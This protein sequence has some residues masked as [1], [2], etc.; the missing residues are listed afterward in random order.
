[1]TNNTAH[2]LPERSPQPHPLWSRR[3]RHYDDD[4]GCE[5]PSS[6]RQPRRRS[7]GPPQ[8]IVIDDE[9]SMVSRITTPTFVTATTTSTT[10][11]SPPPPN[12]QNNNDDTTIK[13][14]G[15]TS[16][17]LPPPSKEGDT[18]NSINKVDI[19]E[20]DDDDEYDR[21]SAYSAPFPP[22]ESL[23][24]SHS[25]FPQ[26]AGGSTVYPGAVAQYPS[27]G[28]RVRSPES[29]IVGQNDNDNIWEERRQ[30]QQ[31]EGQ[32]P[33]AQL[34]EDYVVT[35]AVAITRPTSLVQVDCIE[36]DEYDDDTERIHSTST[37]TGS[38]FLDPILGKF[39]KRTR[40]I[41]SIVVLIG[42]LSVII[43]VTVGVATSRVSGDGD[44][45]AT[46]SQ[47]PPLRPTMPPTTTAQNHL[48]EYVDALSSQH[49]ITVDRRDLSNMSSPQYKALSW[50]AI[51]DEF[52][53]SPGDPDMLE[54]YILAVFYFST[55]GDNWDINNQWF[56]EKHI[57]K[58]WGVVGCTNNERVTL[59]DMGTYV[60][61][62][63]SIRLGY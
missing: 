25:N 28:G 5:Q 55:D 29:L 17:T 23:G 2:G 20:A 19:E 9:A 60:S 48:K 39:S 14:V 57:C 45:G 56:S 62:F 8:D 37:T 16:S 24:P 1:M 7:E 6:Q 18:L 59:F 46:T 27:N 13:S 42:L 10:I 44:D 52:I 61:S 63:V 47:N 58:W 34:A 51:E 11:E 54:R 50:L 26:S 3:A 49:N 12:H 30:Q 4:D 31:Q 40:L 22:P 43:A 36:K 15:A 35:E 21:A 41:M 53:S 32:L 33:E 38:S